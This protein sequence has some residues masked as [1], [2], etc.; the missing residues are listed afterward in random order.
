[1]FLAALNAARKRASLDR[2]HAS[3]CSHPDPIGPRTDLLQ[4]RARPRPGH[5]TTR[6]AKVSSALLETILGASTLS[7]TDV[8]EQA[9]VE[10]DDA[11]R[12]WR[13]LGFPR[14]PDDARV[15]TQ[16]DVA[17]LRAGSEILEREDADAQVLLQITRSSGQALARMT[18]VQV[19]PI[20]KQVLAAMRSRECS[21]SEAVDRVVGASDALLTTVE[22]FLSYAWRRH[23]VAAV[24]QLAASGAHDLADEHHLTVGFA[25]LVGFTAASQELSNRGLA[26]TVDRF[27]RLAYDHI[28]EHGGRVVKMIGDEVMFTTEA[29]EAAAEVALDFLDA[30]AADDVVPE[31]RIG[32]ASGPVLLWEGDVYGSTVNLASRLV[33]I[34]RPGTIL[35]SEQLGGGL[36][37]MDGVS[38][39][40]IPRVN[41]KGIGRTRPRV[42]RRHPPSADRDARET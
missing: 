27:E 10:L 14:I 11:R 1:M 25:D 29:P 41:L 40:E 5:M 4:S 21:D 17:M 7:P 33:N 3:I 28:P 23:L 18:A 9:G 42:L 32:L 8:A 19:V 35:V 2:D 20:A 12:F 39:R 22:P 30:C 24:Q 37:G 16:R 34:A 26:A 6:Y 31:V 36:A 38:L 13:A 15:F